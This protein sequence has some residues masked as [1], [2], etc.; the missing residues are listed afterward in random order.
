MLLGDVKFF[1]GNADIY[2]DQKNSDPNAPID[3]NFFEDLTTMRQV[4]YVVRKGARNPNAAKLFA[5]WATSAEANEIFE[6]YAFIENLVLDRGPISRKITSVLKQNKINVVSWF[7][8]PETVAKFAWFET[9]EGKEYAK[10]VAR[11][12]KDGK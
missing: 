12:Q 5:L 4:L 1:Y 6:K 3:L 9:N 10:A 7:D 8:N 11:A 2:F